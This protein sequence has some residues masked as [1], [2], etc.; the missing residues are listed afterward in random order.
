MSVQ[1]V[2]I[3]FNHDPSSATADAMNLRKNA[4]EFV[5][6]PEW[7]RGVSVNPEDSPAAY[8]LAQVRGHTV[9]IQAK[10]RRLR[11]E[12]QRVEIRALDATID[13]PGKRGCL[14]YI[15]R[16]LHSLFRA[17]FGNVLGEVRA[18]HVTFGAANETG[19]EVFVLE[20]TKL[21]AAF[22]GTRTTAWRWQYRTSPS[23]PWTDFETT[24][25]RIYLVLDLPT[26]PWQQQPYASGN[27]QLPW[28]EA[29]DHACKW[30]LTATDAEDAACRITRAVYQLGP[31]TVTY[32][33]PGGGSTHYAYPAFNCTALLDRLRGGP[34]AGLYVN[35]TDCAT[36][37]ATF[38][39]LLGSDLWQSRMGWSFGLNPLL[40][41]GSSV[42]QPACGWPGFSYHEVAWTGACGLDDHVYDACLQVDG[43]ADPTS[44]PHTP[45]L[46]CNMRFGSPGDGDYRDRLATPAGRPSCNPQPSTRTRRSVF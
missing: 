46:P 44:A 33:C 30:A 24:T 10:F 5:T 15:L 38:S 31:G 29:L 4:S 13:P 18:R 16:I 25:H 45:L 14:G 34:G 41:I 28:T 19:F 6:V 32:D 40:G 7:R 26:A 8:A 39:D 11:P 43:D 9:T 35:C 36:L 23:G 20:H 37:V 12:L 17:L 21:N 1:L 2:A 22:V 3:K 42:W 27:T